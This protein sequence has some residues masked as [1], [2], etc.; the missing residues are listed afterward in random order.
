MAR[1]KGRPQQ[2]PRRVWSHRLQETLSETQSAK[3]SGQRSSVG[4]VIQLLTVSPAILAS[5]FQ[6]ACK[7]TLTVAIF[8]LE[9]GKKDPMTRKLINCG[10]G[11]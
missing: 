7:E 11:I 8:V 10:V 6:E 2:G 4:S 1:I 5:A 9:S 3:C